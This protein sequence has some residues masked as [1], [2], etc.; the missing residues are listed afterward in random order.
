MIS[1]MKTT[2]IERKIEHL[3]Q[4]L[5]ELGPI[6]PGSLSEQTLYCSLK[7]PG[8]MGPSSASC[9]FRCSILRSIGVVFITDIITMISDIVKH[10]LSKIPNFLD[11]FPQPRRFP[12]CRRCHWRYNSAMPMTP[13]M[14][15]FPEL[16]A[17]E[18][19]SVTVPDKEDLPSGEY[20]F[21]ELYCNEPQCDCRRVVVVVLRPETGWK[22]W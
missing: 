17:R 14:K 8:W 21:I 9:C 18:T 10:F 1:D 22:F 7:L 2:P 16:G 13:F 19:R 11:F 6:H 3:K 12:P 20:G 5:A 4:Q 15:R